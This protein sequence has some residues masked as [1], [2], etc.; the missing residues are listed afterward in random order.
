MT[1]RDATKKIIVEVNLP[2][3]FYVSNTLCKLEYNGDYSEYVASLIKRS[4]MMV[5]NKMK[6]E[7]EDDK[8]FLKYIRYVLEDEN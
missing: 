4:C 6:D 5:K 1:N 7:Y 8:K 3:S 2:E